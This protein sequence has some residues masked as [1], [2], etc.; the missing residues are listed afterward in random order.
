MVMAMLAEN[1]PARIRAYQEYVSEEDEKGLIKIFS[2]KRW[3]V[4]LGSE[5]FAAMLT[6]KFFRQKMN[7]EIPQS[8]ELAPDLNHIT[9]IVAKFYKVSPEDLVHSRRGYSNEP[10]N[11]AIYLTRKLRGDTLKTTGN[12][13][14]MDNYSSVSSII[15]RMKAL[16]AQDPILREKVDK[17]VSLIDKSQEQT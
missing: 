16:I 17:L 1:S 2:Q 4:L 10:R 9:K 12:G 13:F 7:I 6:Q 3:P 14:K 8:K 11:V 5:K 15:E